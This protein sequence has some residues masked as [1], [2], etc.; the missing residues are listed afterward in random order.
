VRIA[1]PGDECRCVCGNL[2]ARVVP[3]G[4]ELK[5]R[6]CKRRLVVAVPLAHSVRSGALLRVRAVPDAG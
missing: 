1:D 6:R 4:V 2:V 3:D 5:C